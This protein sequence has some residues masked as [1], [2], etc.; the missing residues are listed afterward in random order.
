L[1]ASSS[2]AFR[3]HFLR[4]QRHRIAPLLLV[5]RRRRQRL[6]CID[7]YEKPDWNPKKRTGFATRLS[8]VKTCIS[9]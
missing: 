2:W 4:P 1:R 9:H 7:D 8:T 6:R 3:S 5:L